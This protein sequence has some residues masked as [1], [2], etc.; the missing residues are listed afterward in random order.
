[1]NK[2]ILIIVILIILIYRNYIYNK[3][4]NIPCKNWDEL[5]NSNRIKD[6]NIY[7]KKK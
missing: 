6:K 1:M 7:K 5:I 4:V 2:L 3:K